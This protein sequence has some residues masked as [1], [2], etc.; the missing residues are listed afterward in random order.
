MDAPTEV[1]A[2]Q[3]AVVQTGYITPDSDVVRFA[4]E[5]GTRVPQVIRLFPTE[6]QARK[7]YKRLAVRNGRVSALGMANSIV[8]QPIYGIAETDLR[9]SRQPATAT[10]EPQPEPPQTGKSRR[11]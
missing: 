7:S 3:W 2:R 11:K 1:V 5:D 9:S 8:C 10:P 4:L 6:E